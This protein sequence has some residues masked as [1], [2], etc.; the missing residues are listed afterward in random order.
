M[1]RITNTFTELRRH[2]A[3]VAFF[4][5]LLIV[6]LAVTVFFW[7]FSSWAGVLWLVLFLLGDVAIL[8]IVC[9]VFSR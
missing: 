6:E 8:A 4:V 3:L 2:P 7:N 9:A 1:S 5:V